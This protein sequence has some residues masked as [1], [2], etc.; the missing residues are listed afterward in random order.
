MRRHRFHATRQRRSGDARP[1]GP[2]G[3]CARPRR[4]LVVYLTW[5]PGEV[6][7][8]WMVDQDPERFVGDVA[9]ALDESETEADT[10]AA[11]PHVSA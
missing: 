7:N 6:R 3:L 10:V 8:Q 9:A 2:F 5:T 4:G 11:T 1:C